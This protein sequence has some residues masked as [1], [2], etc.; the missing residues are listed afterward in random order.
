MRSH[1]LTG[2]VRHRRARPVVYALEHDVYYFALDLDE[3]DVVD[4]SLRLL[5]RN[6]R[7]VLQFRDDDHW[8]EPAADL[9][10]TVLAHLRSEGEDPT[11]WR[12]TLIT[13]VRVFGYVFNPASFFLCR[14]AGG[15]LRMVVVEVHNTHLERHLY[16]LRQDPSRTGDGDDR[17]VGSMDKDFYVSPFIDM[18]GQYTVHVLDEPSRLH[19]AINERQGDAPVL[20]TSLVLVRRPLTDRMLVRML[21]RYPLMTQRTMALIHIHALRLWRKG[22]RFQRHGQAVGAFEASRLV[23]GSLPTTAGHGTPGR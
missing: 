10:A 14:D 23:H 5:S 17:F 8:P 18:E 21:V 12:I 20:A 15:V 13:S 22:V 2:K 19:L 4:G 1:L 6:R 3:L 16:S 11:D 7:N 9:R